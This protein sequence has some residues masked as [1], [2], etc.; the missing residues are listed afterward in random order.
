M[1]KIFRGLAIVPYG[2]IFLIVCILSFVLGGL[3]LVGDYLYNFIRTGRFNE[4]PK[5]YE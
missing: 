3:A 4:E 2:I 5:S 1:I